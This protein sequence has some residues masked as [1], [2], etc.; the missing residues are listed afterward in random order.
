MRGGDPRGPAVARWRMRGRGAPCLASAGRPGGCAA[1][2]RAL[3]AFPEGC[4]TP[5]VCR[6]GGGEEREP[7]VAAVT[8]WTTPGWLLGCGP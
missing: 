1:P 4:G 7:R 5:F 3:V 6:P 2:R 8:G